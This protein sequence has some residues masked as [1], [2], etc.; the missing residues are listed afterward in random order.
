MRQKI[1]SNP[2]SEE[3]IT[4]RQGTSVT[5]RRGTA[6]IAK[7]GIGALAYSGK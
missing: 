3:T 4:T 6:W 1:R 2:S 5:E 7:E